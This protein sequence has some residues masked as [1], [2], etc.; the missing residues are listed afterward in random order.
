MI[1]TSL[2][3][4][5]HFTTNDPSDNHEEGS[6]AQGNLDAGANRHTHGKVHLVAQSD[7]YSSDVLRRVSDNGD[8][9][10][11]DECLANVCS[12]NKGVDA[13]NQVIGTDGDQDC[14]NDKH[15]GCSNWT[16]GGLLGLLAINTGRV[17]GVEKVAVRAQLEDEVE[18]IQD[19]ENDGSSAGQNQDAAI[20]IAV[21]GVLLVENAIEL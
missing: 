9:N 2:K 12:L 6:D 14:D 13:S 10:Q 15:D 8:Q 7:D 20:P 21:A 11:T 19:E 5:R 18:G 1:R 16:H 3:V 4:K 17:F